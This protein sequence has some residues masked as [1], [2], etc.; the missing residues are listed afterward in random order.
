ML[1]E[2]NKYIADESLFEESDKLLLAVSGGVDSMVMLHLFQQLPY[3]FTVVHCNFNLRG[4]ESDE[5]EIFLSNYCITN[6]ISLKIKHFD[7]K[8]FAQQEG[9]SIEM[10]ARELRYAWFKEVKEKTHSQ[11]I[12]TAHHKDD[13]IETILINLTRGTGIKGLTGIQAKQTDLVRPLLFASRKDIL[14]FAEENRLP[15]RHDSS[16]DELV[17]QRNVIRHQIIPLFENLNSAFRNNVVRTATNLQA[18]A[19]LYFSEINRIKTELFQCGKLDIA[20]LQSN[21]YSSTVLFEILAT[22][23]F[24]AAQSTDVYRSLDS[25]SGKV[26]TSKS[27]RL[28]KDRTHLII[29]ELPKEDEGRSMKLFKNQIITE[30]IK[31]GLHVE[32][33]GLNFSF[34]VDSCVAEL[35]ADKLVFPLTLRKW[36]VGDSFIPLG[37]K[38]T[39]KLSDFFTD[40][41][42]SISE[43]ELQWLLCSEDD[44]VWIVGKR[45]GDKFKIT[46]DTKTICKIIFTPTL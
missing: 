15:Y 41:K 16:N 33:I 30:P 17:Y 4:E 28:I 39:K 7:T 9:I 38:G 31:L 46:N 3:A 32:P 10:A 20:K 1:R 24:N 13:L 36:K 27:H 2:L 19:N 35:D 40:Q 23:G 5:E 25:I 18:T 45:I 26:F 43:K 6:N 8:A 29:S 21:A 12:L 42:M 11:Y 37:M 34:T 14:A 44:I 22:Y